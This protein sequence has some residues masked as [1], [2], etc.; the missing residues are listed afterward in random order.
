MDNIQKQISPL[1]SEMTNKKVPKIS[2]LK[3]RSIP[4]WGNAP[5]LR[6][7]EKLRAEGPLY[8]PS[9]KDPYPCSCGMNPTRTAAMTRELHP[10]IFSRVE[11]SV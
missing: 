2:A 10:P 4:A 8:S 7:V 1:R 6:H 11:S 3:A 5:G 9:F